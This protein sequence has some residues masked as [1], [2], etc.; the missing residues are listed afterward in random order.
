[1]KTGQRAVGVT[2]VAA[3]LATALWSILL[4]S[5]EPLPE[6]ALGVP[7]VYHLEPVLAVFAGVVF[8]GVVLH[9]LLRGD[10]VDKVSPKGD[11]EFADQGKPLRELK[12]AV[13]ADVR[14]LAER[15]RHV[16]TRTEALER[17]GSGS[18]ERGTN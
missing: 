12:E 8:V 7:L 5:P 2:A 13:D 15:L 3:A 9:R 4:G 18:P 16:E 6:R 11:L 14:G 1:M 10:A 17:K